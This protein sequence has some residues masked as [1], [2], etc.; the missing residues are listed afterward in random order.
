MSDSNAIIAQV[1]E[2]KTILS[3]LVRR[4]E[5]M[6]IARRPIDFTLDAE[7][8]DAELEVIR[9]EQMAAMAATGRNVTT[10]RTRDLDLPMAA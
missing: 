5:D 10:F 9:L 2:A 7:I 6:L 1:L 3:D 4:S 8:M